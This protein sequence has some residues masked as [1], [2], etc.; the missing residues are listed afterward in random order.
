MIRMLVGLQADADTIATSFLPL[1]VSDPGLSYGIN[2]VKSTAVT[3]N[4]WEEGGA[5]SAGQVTGSVTI[6]PTRKVLELLLEAGGFDRSVVTEDVVLKAPKSAAYKYVTII[7]EYTDATGVA[8]Y[9]TYLGCAINTLAINL[10]PD[11][12]VEAVV[13]PVGVKKPTTTSGAFAGTVTQDTGKTLYCDKSALLLAAEAQEC[14]VTSFNIEINNNLGSEKVICGDYLLQKGELRTLDVSAT[15]PRLVTAE[16]LTEI[17]KAVKGTG[18]VGAVTLKTT[19]EKE[20]IID[21]P[22]LVYK[23]LQ[24]G[25]L[26]GSGSLTKSLTAKWDE[27]AGTAAEFTL[28]GLAAV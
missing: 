16:A 3:G 22:K 8:M 20:V 19:D 4:E 28:K 13:T 6:E 17:D 2:E 12:F 27:T 10:K 5:S 18:I 21:L 15:R 11:A 1:K 23:D 24:K 7:S 14:K 26:K 9:D 25:D